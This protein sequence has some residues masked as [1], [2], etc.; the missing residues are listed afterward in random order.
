MDS[1]P[2]VARVIADKVKEEIGTSASV[3]M[4]TGAVPRP[5]PEGRMLVSRAAVVVVAVTLAGLV[6][7]G[8]LSLYLEMRA[9]R[10]TSVASDSESRARDADIVE[11]LARSEGMATAAE[12]AREEQQR[13]LKTLEEESRDQRHT[14]EVLTEHV[15][16]RLDA[17][18]RRTGADKLAE[19]TDTPADLQLVVVQRRREQ[20]RARVEAERGVR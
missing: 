16:A 7:A 10:D 9:I 13:R 4:V 17:I 11:R 12:Q 18:G 19:W 14:I 8:A 20:E 3:T 15:V 1:V 6:F 2:Q 5:E